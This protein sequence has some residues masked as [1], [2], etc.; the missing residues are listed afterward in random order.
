MLA[1]KGHSLESKVIKELSHP[2]LISLPFVS[3]KGPLLMPQC[4]NSKSSYMVTSASRGADP[5]PN[6]L[7]P[8]LRWIVSGGSL[9]TDGLLGS[10]VACSTFEVPISALWL[11]TV[12]SNLLMG[13]ALAF[14]SGRVTWL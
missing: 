5:R 7:S 13:S 10:G 9:G 2:R 1:A 4:L 12:Q 11:L 8:I 14:F 3:L 6:H